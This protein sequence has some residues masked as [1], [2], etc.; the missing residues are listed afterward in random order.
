MQRA[1]TAVVAAAPCVYYRD[2]L[3]AR[4]R[5]AYRVGDVASKAVVTLAEYKAAS[6]EE[7]VLRCHGRGAAR[8]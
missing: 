2:E 1:V 3:E 6:S 4:A 5:V 8:L 7:E